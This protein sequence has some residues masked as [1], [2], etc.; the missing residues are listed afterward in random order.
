VNRIGCDLD[1]DGD[2]VPYYR[3]RCQTT[4]PW[5]E[6]DEWG[7]MINAVLDDLLFEFDRAEL[8]AAGREF[9][10]K[11][12]A[13]VKA[14]PDVER[15]RIT[16]HADST[17]P[18]RYNQRLSE[19]RAKSVQSYLQRQGVEQPMMVEGRGETQP[20]VSNATR[21]GRAQNRRVE[22]ELDIKEMMR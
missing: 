19:A 12:A 2:G 17:G 4:P 1:I 16:G 7:C 15:L 9:L 18:K 13:A 10:D 8:T 22:I 14:R 11:F 21:A 5:V 6:V 3:D 20:K